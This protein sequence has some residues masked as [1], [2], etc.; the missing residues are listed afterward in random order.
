MKNVRKSGNPE[1]RKSADT[2]V[3]ALDLG[4]SSVRTALFNH[5]GMRIA[6]TTEQRTYSLRTD[7]D[8]RAELDPETV[9][10]ALVE[11]IAGTVAQRRGQP[12]AAVGGSC[13]WHSLIGIDTRA[14]PVTPIITWA[15]S[16]CRDDAARLRIT[17]NERA[18]QAR[19]GCMLRPSFWPAKLAHIKRTAP[20]TW[21]KV[22]WW[23]SPAD[24]LWLRLTGVGVTGHSMA[25]ASGC[26][27]S[28]KRSWDAPMLKTLD[29]DPDRLPTIGDVQFTAVD[30]LARRFPELANAHWFPAL[31]DG[32]AN[33]LGAGATR[34]GLAAINFGTSGAVRIVVPDTRQAKPAPYGL[35]RYRI[36]SQRYLLGGA[37]SNAGGLRAWCLEHLRLPAEQELEEQL[38][39]RPGPAHGLSVLP[40]WMAERA[41][42]WRDDLTG[43]ITG[44]TQST[45]A[46]DLYQAIT[47]ATY[48]R[49]ATIIERLP[50]DTTALRF[51][52]GGGIQKS[53]VAFQR[54]ADVT[55]RT[56]VACD[57][58]ETSLRGAAVF[59][60]E[61][62]GLTATDIGGRTVKPRPRH[63]A[64]YAAERQR[65]ARLEALLSP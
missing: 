35:F 37:I 46:I 11:C 30:G 27:D 33:N 23:L 1:I 5:R 50:G 12:I 18:V 56:L 29:L 20:T 22:R 38:A 2:I 53:A 58:A 64:T 17:C 51:L 49:L 44:I 16:R 34:P 26:Y 61:G 25:S 65:L 41:P 59:A 19:T 55:G 10:A 32:A 8:G 47:E 14:R 6:G 9:L 57:E 15:D 42:T 36:D 63:A 24:W 45:S 4:T 13:F 3:L 21:N 31:G 62:L 28:A 52:V 40:F 7:R 60:L 54:L 39:K 48:H 43:A